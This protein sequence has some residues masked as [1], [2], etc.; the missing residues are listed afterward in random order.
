MSIER[1]MQR[2]VL[3]LPPEA[4]CA[5]AATMMRDENVGAIVISES[6]RPLGMV[7]DRDLVIRVIA[8]GMEAEKTQ[9]R[10]VMS[11]EPI[12]LGGERSI[13]QVIA[14]M[15][16]LAIRRIPV[17][18]HEGQLCG[19]VSMDDMLIL[20]ADQLGDLAQVI[21]QEIGND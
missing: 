7:T 3:R 20:L 1:V 5:E 17:V 4:T 15:R 11:G 16:N 12:F 14:A 18:D 19:L 21:R 10:D 6:G 2:P 8:D 13:E 9:L